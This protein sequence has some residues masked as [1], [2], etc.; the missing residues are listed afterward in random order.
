MGKLIGTIVV[1]ETTYNVTI[2]PTHKNAIEAIRR[3]CLGCAAE[4]DAELCGALPACCG[5]DRDDKLDVVFVE[6]VGT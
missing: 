3:P 1:N 6:V 2:G 5:W 4:Y